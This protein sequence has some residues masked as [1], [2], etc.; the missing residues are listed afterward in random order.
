M[1]G[2]AQRLV[3][4]PEFIAGVTFGTL[5]LTMV[6]LAS[7]VWRRVAD[8][9]P[10]PVSGLVPVATALLALSR[11]GRGSTWL[12]VGL[13]A[14]IVASAA[15]AWLRTS[16][17]STAFLVAPGAAVIAYQAL[18]GPGW[19]RHVAF[20]AITTGGALATSYGAGRG[21]QDLGPLLL[22]ISAGGI[23]ATVPDTEHAL[24]LLGAT[25]PLALTGWPLLWTRL[26]AVGAPAW[27]ALAIWTVASGGALRT[28]AVVGGIGSLGV[29]VLEPTL[30]IFS[31]HHTRAGTAPNVSRLGELSLHLGLVFI[32]SRVAGLR[33]SLPL[34]IAILVAAYSA[35]A[36]GLVARAGGSRASGPDPTPS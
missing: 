6:G 29:L 21:H 11:V 1:T 31:R 7:L 32:S 30:G 22:S 34:S 17:F 26:G 3:E 19:I 25:A 10:I 23:W 13:G 15:G 27:V 2:I 14:V 8:D 5:A 9:R 24:A 12:L 16:V 28:T 18:S 35:A 4:S 36:W 33:R 20:V